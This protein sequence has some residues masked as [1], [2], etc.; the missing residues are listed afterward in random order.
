MNLPPPRTCAR[1]HP[2]R[3]R[4][5]GAWSPWRPGTWRGGWGSRGSWSWSS[6]EGPPSVRVSL[7]R[8]GGHPSRLHPHCTSTWGAAARLHALLTTGTTIIII[9]STSRSSTGARGARALSLDE[10]RSFD[11]L[12]H[13]L[14]SAHTAVHVHVNCEYCS[15]RVK[16]LYL[17]LNNFLQ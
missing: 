1:C 9:I 16:V 13:T 12:R 14:Y 2:G 5:A 10:W 6:G 17:F 8:S 7:G 4:A 11:S 15:V 3:W